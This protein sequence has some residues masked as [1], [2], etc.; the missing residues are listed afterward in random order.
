MNAP[1]TS[2]ALGTSGSD[3]QIAP[4]RLTGVRI[5]V[6]GLLTE[7]PT[8]ADLLHRLGV[9][10]L[11]TH[12][13]LE[14]T[15]SASVLRFDAQYVQAI[16]PGFNTLEVRRNMPDFAHILEP[17]QALR[18]EV[19]VAMLAGPE[20]YEFPSVDEF[21]SAINMRCYIV[22]AARNT[23]LSFHTQ[24]ASRP[25]RWWIYDDDRGFLLCPG[26]S[27]VE[28]LTRALH[29]DGQGAPH[30]FSCYRASEYV[31]L[32]GMAQELQACNAPLYA[33]LE[34]LWTQRSIKSREF[35]EVFLC[36]YGSMEEPLPMYYYVPGDRVW[37]RNPDPVSA[38]IAGYEGSWVIY[39]GGGLFANFWKR[40]QPYTLQSKCLEIYHWRNAVIRNASGTEEIDESQVAALVA[41]GSADASGTGAIFKQMLRYREARGEFTSA[42]GCMDTTR[43]APKRVR[44]GCCN[45][46]LPAPS[47]CF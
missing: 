9:P 46:A 40:S 37:F 5:A 3:A 16:A 24:A 7:C 43:E 14:S 23:A 17:T 13:H 1:G 39:L 41:A 22:G 42:G 35:H 19:V 33:Q 6:D 27:L 34:T 25:D 15:P 12:V 11:L 10:E 8:C 45:I 21:V 2:P 38:D 18:C 47:E 30:S 20:V 29:G 32:L 44:P 26:I 4:T 31:V 36:E 28:A